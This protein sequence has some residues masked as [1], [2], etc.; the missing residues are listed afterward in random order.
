MDNGELLDAAFV[1]LF[2][3][4]YGNLR[5]VALHIC[6]DDEVADELCQEAFL[7]YYERRN[8]LPGGDE[9]R[10]WLI[11]VIK[12]LTFNHE[13]RRGHEY[14]VYR[15]YAQLMRVEVQNDGERSILEDDVC[16]NVRKTLAMVP[17]KLRITLVLKEYA[18]FSYST[19]AK[20]LRISE[21]NVKVRVCRARQHLS[22]LLT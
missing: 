6:G 19:I 18:G 14:D 17:Y 3:G 12:N 15:K 8:H 13:K 2:N 21:N 20:I 4:F 7:R 16:E 5:R 1:E 11:R 10:Y 22:K 9:A